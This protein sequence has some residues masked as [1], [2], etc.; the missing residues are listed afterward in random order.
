VYQSGMDK[1]IYGSWGKWKLLEVSQHDLRQD[2][3]YYPWLLAAVASTPPERRRSLT[4]AWLRSPHL[5]SASSIELPRDWELYY[6]MVRL[7]T[8]LMA[9]RMLKSAD[10]PSLNHSAR[11]FN[12]CARR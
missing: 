10:D 5:H 9:C 7:I 1:V 4:L 8:C 3:N 11:T 2:A 6:T 12:A